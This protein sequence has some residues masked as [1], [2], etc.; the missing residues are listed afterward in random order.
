MKI[1]YSEVRGVLGKKVWKETFIK[2]LKNASSENVYFL[3][4]T[5]EH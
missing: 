5:V 1:L 2:G 3:T 4:E